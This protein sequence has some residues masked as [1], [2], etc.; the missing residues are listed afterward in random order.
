[1]VSDV[2]G[3]VE[4]PEMLLQQP[5]I[6]AMQGYVSQV[7]KVGEAERLVVILRRLPRCRFRLVTELGEPLAGAGVIASK[8]VIVGKCN[9]DVADVLPAL[10]HDDGVFTAVAD[11]E[12]TAELAFPGNGEYF[13]HATW[14]WGECIDEQ[15]YERPMTLRDGMEVEMQ[16]REYIGIAVHGHGEDV[17]AMAS[18]VDQ[19]SKH[20]VVASA[21]H[22]MLARHYVAKALRDRLGRGACVSWAPQAGVDSARVKVSGLL[23]SGKKFECVL[24]AVHVRRAALHEVVGDGQTGWLVVQPINAQSI[25]VVITSKRMGWSLEAA[26]GATVELPEGAYGVSY[27]GRSLI[28]AVG[29]ASVAVREG[30]VQQV[31]VP[32][33]AGRPVRLS[34]EAR[35]MPFLGMVQIGIEAANRERRWI[36]NWNPAVEKWLWVEREPISVSVACPG[37]Q[38]QVLDV[39]LL[40]ESIEVVWK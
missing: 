38:R 19:L 27:K 6:V 28:G 35:D 25:P 5:L 8:K 7:V 39:P 34:F 9:M 37:Y 2:L 3:L 21:G 22:L 26:E 32:A 1:M 17:V 16:F 18:E 31:E 24:D 33:P 40:Q 30:A 14:P 23:K 11:A 13:L 10:S 20:K 12:G 15:I 36:Y 29:A 4:I